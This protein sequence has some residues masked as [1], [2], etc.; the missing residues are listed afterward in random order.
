MAVT[1]HLPQGRHQAGTATS[2]STA[3]GTTSQA[4][5]GGL[6]A[7]G[8]SGL[9]NQVI[10]ALCVPGIFRGALDARA[11]KITGATEQTATTA[12]A[13]TVS[14]NQRRIGATATRHRRQPRTRRRHHPARPCCHR[15]DSPPGGA[16]GGGLTDAAA[17]IP[18]SGSAGT[19]A[20]GVDAPRPG[21]GAS[22]RSGRG[23]AAQLGPHG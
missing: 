6:L 4:V 3:S 15:G 5:G 10:H 17:G 8:R 12:I 16:G 13:D 7:T 21:R 19:A 14:D 23:R 2:T 20:S 22:A 9:P 11:P 1:Q 18:G